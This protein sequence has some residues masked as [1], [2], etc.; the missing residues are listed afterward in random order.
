MYTIYLNDLNSYAINILYNA[1][2][3][4]CAFSFDSNSYQTVNYYQTEFGKRRFGK[5]AFSFSA[6]S[7]CNSI[8]IEYQI[9]SILPFLIQTPCISQFPYTHPSVV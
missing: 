8:A 6:P 5:R 3:W 9:L 4:S 7:V 2:D 1:V